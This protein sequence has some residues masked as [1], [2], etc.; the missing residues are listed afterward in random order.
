MRLSVLT[1]LLLFTAIQQPNPHV[2]PHEPSIR[3]GD[4]KSETDGKQQELKEKPAITIQECEHCTIIE[5]CVGC[6]AEEKPYAQRQ[7]SDSYDAGKDTLYRVY[8]W[9]TI[10]GILVALGGVLAIYKQT[11]ATKKAADATLRSAKAAERSVKLQ[12]NTQRQWIKLEDWHAFRIN[13]TDPLEVAFDV[14]NPTTLPLTLHGII[15]KINGKPAEDEVPIKVLTPSYPFKHS[16][17]VPLDKEQESLYARD[18]LDLNIECTVLFADCHGIH[19][20]HEFGRMLHCR[21]TGSF[22]TDTKET[23]T[24]SGVPGERGARDVELS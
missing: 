5:K 22:V 16:V 1:A 6:S 24:E 17:G 11:K 20:C 2:L 10:I 3:E 14:I 9:F 19:W 8:L 13:P 7:Q 12:E 15:T 21:H 23:L 18:A 4:A